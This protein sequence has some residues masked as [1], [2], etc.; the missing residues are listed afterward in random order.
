MVGGKVPFVI[1]EVEG[2]HDHD[3]RDC[4]CWELKISRYLECL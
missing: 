2:M 4:G 3:K 1:R